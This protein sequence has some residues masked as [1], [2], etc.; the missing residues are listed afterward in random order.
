MK[1]KNNVDNAE[2]IVAQLR[3]CA[4]TI[5]N[6]DYQMQNIRDKIDKGDSQPPL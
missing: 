2:E 3:D 5:E 6:L 1:Y 4:D